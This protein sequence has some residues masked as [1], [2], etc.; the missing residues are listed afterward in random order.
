MNATL[1]TDG[2]P[3]I[4]PLLIGS[5]NTVV[6]AVAFPSNVCFLLAIWKDKVLSRMSAYQIIFH[7]SVAHVLLTVSTFELGLVALFSS[8]CRFDGW[9]VGIGS[10]I[11]YFGPISLCILSAI[12]ALNRLAALAPIHCLGDLVFKALLWFMWLLIVSSGLALILTGT[13]FTYR[14]DDFLYHFYNELPALTIFFW[15][16]LAFLVVGVVLYCLAILSITLRRGATKKC[17][18]ALLIQG[19]IPFLY[20]ALVRSLQNFPFE[21]SPT[22]YLIFLSFAFRSLP[23]LHVAVYLL[24]NRTLREAVLR[25]LSLRRPKNVVAINVIASFKSV[26][27]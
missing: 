19:A 7:M 4:H 8:I 2:P 16:T 14:T 26:D 9:I 22:L 15:L 21:H 3:R 12:Q 6:F 18:V 24:F 17:D 20:L 5:Y 13:I 10:V 23:L 27:P 11:A 1:F 25:L